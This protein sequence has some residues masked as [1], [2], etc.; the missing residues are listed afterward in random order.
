MQSWIDIA[1]NHIQDMIAETRREFPD[2]EFRVAFVGYRDYGDTQLNIVIPF[3]QDLDELR[4]RI[5]EVEAVGGSD[6]AE[7]VA[8]GLLLA[9]NLFHTVP[10]DSVRQIVHI[11]DAPAHGI[12]FHASYVTDRFPRGDPDGVDILQ[13]IR[14]ISR[15]ID[16]TF[17]KV[18][19]CTNRMIEQ[20]HSVW[21]SNRL[22]RV[23][24]LCSRQREDDPV[25]P[26]TVPVAPVLRAITATLSA[27]IS[28]YTSSQDS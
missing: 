20:F 14:D 1:K 6:H 27:S 4:L 22:F 3:L 13:C 17:V 7:D 12:Q 23:L 25:A 19:S 24:D 5:S 28:H 15:D 9:H 11:A 10:V 18:H 26:E 2:T 21:E 8:N 16:Y